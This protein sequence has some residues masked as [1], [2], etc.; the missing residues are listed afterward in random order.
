[1]LII[2]YKT[3]NILKELHYFYIKDSKAD[4]S[5]VTIEFSQKIDKKDNYVIKCEDETYANNISNSL[6]EEII[7]NKEEAIDI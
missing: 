2:D 4:K 1:M 3:Y 7:N 5:E 6:N